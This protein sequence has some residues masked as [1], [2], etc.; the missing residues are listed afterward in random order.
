MPYASDAQRKWAHTPAGTK[1]LGGAGKVAEWDQ[2]SEGANLPEHVSKK[3]KPGR[4]ASAIA[5]FK[6]KHRR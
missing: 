5:A 1:A 6:A 3:K 2:A 4:A